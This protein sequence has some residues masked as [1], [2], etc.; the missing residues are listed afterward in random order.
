MVAVALGWY[1][2]QSIT[3]PLAELASGA[4][5]LARGDFR[6]EVDVGGNDELAVVGRAFNHAARQLQ[7]LYEELRDS[8][9]QWRAAFESNPTMYFIIDAGGNIVTVNTFGAEKL[10]YNMDELM[11]RPVLSVFYEPDKEA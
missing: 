4:Q 9:E 11:G 8:E 1:A 7:E 5:A 10:G 2:T 3:V 6:R